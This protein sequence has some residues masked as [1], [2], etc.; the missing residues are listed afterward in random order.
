MFLSIKW[1]ST[2]EGESGSIVGCGPRFITDGNLILESLVKLH[3]A[4][5]PS[6]GRNFL[7]SISRFAVGNPISLPRP[8]PF[9]TLPKK[10]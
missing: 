9:T 2:A 10:L 7:P 8:L 3:A 1:I 5:T 6:P 4:Y